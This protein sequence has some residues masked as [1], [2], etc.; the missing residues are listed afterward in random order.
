MKDLAHK[1]ESAFKNQGF[2]EKNSNFFAMRDFCEHGNGSKSNPDRCGVS[3]R[4]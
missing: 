3:R 4:G 1:N 2:Y